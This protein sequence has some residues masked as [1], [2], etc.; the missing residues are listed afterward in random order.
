MKSEVVQ[1]V[2]KCT[3]VKHIT[4]YQKHC[5]E[6]AKLSGYAQ[7]AMLNITII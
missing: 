5:L 2:K 1:N 6:K 7:I 4:R 3:I